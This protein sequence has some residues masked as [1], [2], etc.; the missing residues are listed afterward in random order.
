MQLEPFTSFSSWLSS[1]VAHL[2]RS[3]AEL[4]LEPSLSDLI[5]TELSSSQARTVHE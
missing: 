5:L 4:E 2:V 1:Y 3:R